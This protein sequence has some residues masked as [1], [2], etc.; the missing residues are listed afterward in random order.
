MASWWGNFNICPQLHWVELPCHSQVELSSINSLKVWGTHRNPTTTWPICWSG[1]RTSQRVDTMA[2]PLYGSTPTK[3]GLNCLTL[4]WHQLALCP[5]TAMQGSP[6][7]IT[8]QEQTPRCPI[9]GKGTENLLWPDQPTQ[10]LP[11]ACHQVSSH[12]PHRF[13]L[14]GWTCYNDS[15]RATGQQYKPHC[16]WTYLLG[17]WHP[18]TPSGGTRTK[19]AASWGHPY[20]PENQSPQISHKI[21]RKYGGR[22]Q[23]SAIP[24][25]VRSIQLWVLT[26]IPK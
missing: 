24:C 15:T 10:S 3:S 17:D 25:G 7:C 19:D 22:G 2:S 4:Q 14:A 1:L 8:P 20:H 23:Q 5:I 21:Q 16:K 6:S 9:S 26:I 11:A 12:L 18:F 13:E